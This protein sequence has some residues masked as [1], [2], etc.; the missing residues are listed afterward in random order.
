MCNRYA[1]DI[2]KAGLEKEFYGFE[3]WS[4]TLIKPRNMSEDT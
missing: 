1:A 3:E 4:E 2:G